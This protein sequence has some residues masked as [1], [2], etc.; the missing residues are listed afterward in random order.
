MENQDTAILEIANRIRKLVKD[1][2]K[3]DNYKEV[4]QGGNIRTEGSN[5]EEME[6]NMDNSDN[7]QAGFR[8]VVPWEASGMEEADKGDMGNHDVD[9]PKM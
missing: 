8:L 2:N 1:T 5:T 9:N 4:L 7:F 3:E 6:V